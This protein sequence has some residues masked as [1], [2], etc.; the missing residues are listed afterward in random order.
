M[1][2]RAHDLDALLVD[3]DHK[4]A[5]QRPNDSIDAAFSG[6]Q[7]PIGARVG[8]QTDA[9]KKALCGGGGAVHICVGAYAFSAAHGQNEV[10]GETA[11]QICPVAL[12]RGGEGDGVDGT[13]KIAK[14]D[15]FLVHE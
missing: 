8:S 12:V 4:L 15:V 9:P 3:P 10:A 11:G 13:G 5:R 2:I 14:R 7:N 1:K 6:M